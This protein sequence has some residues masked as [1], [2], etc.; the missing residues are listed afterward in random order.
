MFGQDHLVRAHPQQDLPLGAGAG[1][2]DHP[3][4]AQLLQQDRGQQIAL[5]IRADA[6]QPRVEILHPGLAQGVDVG[7][8]QLHDMGQFGA[9]LLHRFMSESMASTSLPY[10]TKVVA[11]VVPK[12]PRPITTNS[13]RLFSKGLYRLR[14]LG[15]A[16][17]SPFVC[18][19]WN[20][21]NE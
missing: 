16:H 5:E 7:G 18:D 13:L 3:L 10:L 17:G 1:L 19:E 8:V 15:F 12:R 11:T 2:G 4:D 21:S 9:E 20:R 6:D 14:C